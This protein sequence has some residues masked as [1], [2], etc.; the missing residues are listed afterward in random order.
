M[1]LGSMG[2]AYFLE[3]I[4]TA[5]PNGMVWEEWYGKRFLNER[6]EESLKKEKRQNL[7]GAVPLTLSH[8]PLTFL[9]P[10]L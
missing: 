6:G 2:H 3:P 5:F 1:H 4:E 9:H 8:F 7:Y 10:Y